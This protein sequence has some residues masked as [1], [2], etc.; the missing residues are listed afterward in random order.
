[1]NSRKFFT[2]FFICALVPLIAAKLSLIT[3][4][5]GHKSNNKG[6]WLAHEIQLL[7]NTLAANER[8]RLVYVQSSEEC[9][10][11]CDK[12]LT[13]LQQLYVG[14]G[15]KQ[16]GIKPLVIATK[17]PEALS[18]FPALSWQPESKPV[19]E[20]KNQIV[21]VNQQGLVLLRYFVADDAE[22]M[23][24]TAKDIRSDLL[25]LMN[26]DRRGV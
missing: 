25:H 10:Q 22:K 18:R 9:D 12:A 26:Y 16:L 14:L 24:T 19:D 13:I 5:L 11:H 1:M 2:L 21:I 4:F 3:G 20:L 15:R 7:P 6:A 8:W 17:S 23:Q